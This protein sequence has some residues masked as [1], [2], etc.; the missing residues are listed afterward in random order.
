MPSINDVIVSSSYVVVN[1]VVSHRPNENAGGS[2]GL[3]VRSV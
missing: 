3:P 2:E 1:E